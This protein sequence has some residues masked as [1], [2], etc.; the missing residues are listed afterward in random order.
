VDALKKL[1]ACFLCLNLCACTRSSTAETRKSSPA[2][3]EDIV[4]DQKNEVALYLEMYQHL[5][6]CYMTKKEARKKGGQAVLC[7]KQLKADA[8]AGMSMA[9]MK[10]YCRRSQEH[11]MNAI[12]IR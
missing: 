7:M 1:L 9:T 6:S 4:T 8:S 2:I 11:I 10:R 5:P 12:S 3:A